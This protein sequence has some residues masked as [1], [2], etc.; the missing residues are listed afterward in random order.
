MLLLLLMVVV[1]AV[2]LLLLLKPG[3]WGMLLLCCY[4]CGKRSL[5]QGACRRPCCRRCRCKHLYHYADIREL[6]FLSRGC[7]VGKDVQLLT[8]H[9]I[10]DHAD[11]S[12]GRLCVR[13][14]LS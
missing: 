11:V 6:L 10:V 13:L 2:L 8:S 5:Q 14:C 4:C 12:R 7:L 9:T 1:M 3:F